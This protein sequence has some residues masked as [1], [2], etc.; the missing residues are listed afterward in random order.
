MALSL[1]TKSRSEKWYGV[2]SARLMHEAFSC[3]RRGKM[4][5]TE[6]C[7]Y[8]AV[9]CRRISCQAR[10][11]VFDGCASH[12]TAPWVA[13]LDVCEAW[14]SQVRPV[15]SA[16]RHGCLQIS[17]LFCVRLPVG[18]FAVRMCQSPVVPFIQVHTTVR[19]ASLNG[20]SYERV[21]RAK[22]SFRRFSLQ[23]S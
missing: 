16:I 6:I 17:I 3:H 13:A 19:D 12:L 22:R 8:C 5:T 1:L 4:S 2:A 20:F 10:P 15:V 18:L 14:P 9:E 21:H 23:K 7:K 11:V